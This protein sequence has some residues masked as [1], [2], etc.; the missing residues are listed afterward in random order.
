MVAAV[1]ASGGTLTALVGLLTLRLTVDGSF[2]RYVQL[3]MRPW[4][5]VAGTALLLL[6]LVTLARA[7]R[8]DETPDQVLHERG[9][10]HGVGVGWLLLVPMATLLLV[11]P[12]SLGSYAVDRSS[13]V[14]VT[15]GRSTLPP[16]DTSAGLVRMTLL[17]Y[18]ERSFD[19]D[20]SS[21]SG[22]TIELT[23]FVAGDDGS[24]GFRLARYQIACCAADAAAAVVRVEGA[25]TTPARDQWVTVTGSFVDQ[26][27]DPAIAATAIEEIEP[28]EDPYE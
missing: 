11:A 18:I 5:L 21:L 8:T 17:E 2:Q 10:E 3:G 14:Q 20:G 25:A 24:E 9:H 16:L 13:H 19:H 28:P 1:T 12:P 26:G 7:L 27:G 6:G 4:L 15:S 22:A 23:G